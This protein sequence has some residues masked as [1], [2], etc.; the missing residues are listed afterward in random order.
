MNAEKMPYTFLAGQSFKAYHFIIFKGK[1]K[2]LAPSNVL[3]SI[4]YQPRA[5]ILPIEEKKNH[6]IF[7]NLHY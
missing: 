1:S 3:K 2:A 6:Q 7:N 5:L 4:K